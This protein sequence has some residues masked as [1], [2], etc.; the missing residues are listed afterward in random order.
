MN[1]RT[2]RILI[3]DGLVVTMDPDLGVFHGSVLVE[4]GVIAAV[5][6]V[7]AALDAVDEVIDATDML[8][9]P[10]FVDSH[11]HLWETP[12]RGIASEFWGLEYFRV[13]HPMS[14]HYRPEDVYAATYAGAIELLSYGITSTLDYCHSANSPAH[15]DAAVAA[16]RDSG[17]TALY[18]FAFLARESASYP[19]HAARVADAARIR[20]EHFATDDG[21]V[22]MAVGLSV[23]G[24][25]SEAESL[26][27][28]ACA[29]ELGVLISAHSNLPYEI[30]WFEER[31]LLGPDMLFV[32]CNVA[33]DAELR[34]MADNGVSLSISPSI[35]AGMGKPYDILG[36][37]FRAG[38]R[39][40]LSTDAVPCVNADPLVQMRLAWE[41][42]RAVDGRL[43]REQNRTPRPVRRDGSPLLSA[44]D[45]LHAMTLGAAESLG[46]GDVTGSLTPG[47]QADLVLVSTAPFGMSL[48]NPYAHVVLETSAD[49]IDTVI[50]RGVVRKRGG[51]LVGVDLQ[52]MR[53]ELDASRTYLLPYLTGLPIPTPIHLPV[54]AAAVPAS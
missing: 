6:D 16:L 2:R 38:V 43:E 8:V 46:L 20:R 52:A 41:L 1:S 32:H 26:A 42:Q 27:E 9:L 15:A 35:E 36:R 11:M 18:A 45:V 5:G 49:K 39:V 13:V 7:P 19:N 29:R 23:L 53:R 34:T 48:A 24:A 40:S 28:I 3:R 25:V 47:K 10:G 22:R 4:D 30:T 31:R 33:T 54:P 21:P 50:A 51:S 14:N 17:L 37:A 12:L 44:E